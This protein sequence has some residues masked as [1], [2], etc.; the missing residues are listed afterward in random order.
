ML[1]MMKICNAQGFEYGIISGNRKPVIGA[2]DNLREWWKNKVRFDRNGPAAI[3]KYQV[4]NS[5]QDKGDENSTPLTHPLLE[6]QEST[7]GCSD[8][9][10]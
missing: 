1:K 4:D 2:S 6:L 7:L 9:S 8:S 5:I 3:A 10:M